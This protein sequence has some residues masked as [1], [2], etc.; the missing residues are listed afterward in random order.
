MRNNG[1][2]VSLERFRFWDTLLEKADKR[3][4]LHTKIKT[5]SKPNGV[6][7]GIG[8][9]G[10]S[11][12]YVGSNDSAWVELNINIKGNVE[13]TEKIYKELLAVSGN[14]DKKYPELKI[15]WKPIEK[16]PT[17]SR[18]VLSYSAK[19]GISDTKHWDDIQNDLIDR[20]V[21]FEKIFKNWINN[22]K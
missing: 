10:I 9:A 11:L 3:T 22:Y 20:M 16:S 17:N 4:K 19:G 7:A 14:I 8:I 18:L 13:E 21:K 5:I 1:D 6:H 15:V 2:S 12:G